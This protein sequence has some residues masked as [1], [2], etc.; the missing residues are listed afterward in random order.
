MHEPRISVQLGRRAPATIHSST[1]RPR[2]A[3]ARTRGTPHLLPIPLHHLR[4]HPQ[5][6][7]QMLHRQMPVQKLGRMVLWKT[8]LQEDRAQLA[9][10]KPLGGVTPNLPIAR[11]LGHAVRLHIAKEQ[12]VLVVAFVRDEERRRVERWR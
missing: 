9:F 11:R 5:F 12:H 10:R 6:I 1:S 4:Q 3:I 7:K 2:T 8:A